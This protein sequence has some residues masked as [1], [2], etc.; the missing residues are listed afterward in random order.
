MPHPLA[1]FR[2]EAEKR[3]ADALTQIAPGTETEFLFSEPPA[4]MGELAAACF[5]LAKTLKRSPH[6]IAGELAAELTRQLETE[7]QSDTKATQ[8]VTKAEAAGPYVNLQLDTS[9]ATRMLIAQAHDDPEGFG[10]LPARKERVILE[11]T[12][13]NPTGP[14]HVGRARNPIIGDT[15]VRLYRAAGY[16]TTAQYY[17]DDMGKQVAILTWAVET[18]SEPQ[19]TE[20][21]GPP[22]S[23]KSDHRLVRYY[24]AA[25]QLMEQDDSVRDTIQTLVRATEEG[26]EGTLERIHAG[27]RGVFDGMLATLERLNVDF[28]ETIH[29]SRFVTNGDTAKVIERLAEQKEVPVGQEGEALYLDLATKGVTGKSTR[30]YFR[31]GDGTSL[32]ATRDVA[33]HQWK[34]QQADRLVNVL[35]EDHKLQAKQVRICL[36]LLGTEPLPEV[37]FYSFVSLPEGRMTTRKGRVVYLDDLFEEAVE[38]AYVEVEKRRRG[39]LDETQMRRI[40][41][42]VGVGAVRFTI[43][44]VQCEKAIRFKWEEALSFDGYAAPFVQYSHAR[45]AGIL[46]R[47]EAN[48]ITPDPEKAGLLTHES[49]EALVKML[50]KLPQVVEDAA[51]KNRP[52]LV[53]QYAYDL[54]VA[55]NAFY[56]DCRVVEAETPELSQARLGLV[57]AARVALANAL[58][59]IGVDAPAEM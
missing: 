16:Q 11:H 38:R 36:E 29:E 34:A 13:A 35:G 2:E 5:P 52:H 32:Y 31:R 23:D 8:W 51:A 42:N 12:S 9:R 30:F 3:L 58:G 50:A 53:P 40:A 6:Q 21:V 47:A 24:Q 25:N 26:D 22:K 44:K 14:L 43:A 19:V 20:L 27:Y 39:E 45:V 48:G 56:R 17:M 59:L 7:A 33:Y 54:A 37:V 28:D 4:G 57:E 18:L 1:W 41:Q 49:E 46:K 55:F 10:R 15:L